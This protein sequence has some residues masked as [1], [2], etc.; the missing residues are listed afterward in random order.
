MKR[1]KKYLTLLLALVLLPL[2]P[3][4]QAVVGGVCIRWARSGVRHGGCR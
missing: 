4:V 3:R 2:V 1:M